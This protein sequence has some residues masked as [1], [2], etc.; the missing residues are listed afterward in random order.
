M[1]IV[2]GFYTG[3]VAKARPRAVTPETMIAT[4][5]ADIGITDAPLRTLER[6]GRWAAI[7]PGN[8]IAWFPRDEDGR[9]LLARERMVLRLIEKHCSFSAPHVMHEGSEGWDLRTMVPGDSQPYEIHAKACT[10]KS[11]A[12]RIGEA[13]GRI[14]AD[15][16]TNIPTD[17]LKGWLPATRD[18]PRTEDLPNIPHVVEDR[19]LLSRIDQALARRDAIIHAPGVR[20]LTHCDLGFHNIAFDPATLEVRGVFDY[21]GAAFSDRHFDFKNLLVHGADDVEPVLD[22][23]AY[24]YEDLTGVTVDLDRVR[25]FNAIEAIGFLAYRFGHAPEEEWCGRTLAQDLAWADRA[26]RDAGID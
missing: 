19:A 13:L 11:L 21:E 5:L 10:D 22:A 25:L 24:V 6:D 1:D 4:A 7:L 8:R 9:S 18:W 3:R 23:A 17:E 26:L 14:I 15:Q 20:V 16:H 12:R 2:G